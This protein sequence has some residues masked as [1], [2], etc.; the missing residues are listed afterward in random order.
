MA[1]AG[2]A[3]VPTPISRA[4]RTNVA[5]SMASAGRT[6]ITSTATPATA[7]PATWAARKVA[8]VTDAPSG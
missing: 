7:T 6:P 3:L 2:R 4:E 8:W 5:A 1:A